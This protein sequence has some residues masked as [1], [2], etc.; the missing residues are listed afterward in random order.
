MHYNLPPIV[1]L[2]LRSKLS[3]KNVLLRANISMGGPISIPENLVVDISEK[4]DEIALL[5]KSTII[6]NQTIARPS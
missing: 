4:C 6:H 1:R 5:I 2:T 3:S